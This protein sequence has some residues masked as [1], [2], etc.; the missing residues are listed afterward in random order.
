M[1]AVYR[2]LVSIKYKESGLGTMLSTQSLPF[3]GSLL[4]LYILLISMQ[5]RA[6]KENSNCSWIRPGLGQL[7]CQLEQLLSQHISL[8][9]VILERHA[10]SSSYL[11]LQLRSKSGVTK[12]VKVAIWMPPKPKYK[13]YY[14]KS[15]VPHNFL[16]K[17][18][19]M[20]NWISG[21]HYLALFLK[22]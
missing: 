21:I 12:R 20:N 18:R 2:D 11:F 3:P 14:F 15:G 9:I 10:F 1:Q 13:F 22:Y 5:N 8:V 4:T 19:F 7:F 16:Y 17:E 6:W